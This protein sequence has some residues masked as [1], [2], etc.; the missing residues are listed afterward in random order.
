VQDYEAVRDQLITA[1]GRCQAF[2]VVSR[3]EGMP[4]TDGIGRGRRCCMHIFVRSVQA[5]AIAASTGG[6]PVLMQIFS[7]LLKTFRCRSSS[8]SISF[9]RLS[10]DLLNG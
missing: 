6:P 2:T 9:R 4:R 1:F 8:S 3:Y 5:I 7:S 10:R